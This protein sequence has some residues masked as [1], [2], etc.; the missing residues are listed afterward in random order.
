MTDRKLPEAARAFDAAEIGKLL[1]DGHT[2][3]LGSVI[4][5]VERGKLLA[6]CSCWASAVWPVSM[7][8]GSEAELRDFATFINRHNHGAS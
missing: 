3:K 2:V 8:D 4:L 5:A 7:L 1:R 6:R